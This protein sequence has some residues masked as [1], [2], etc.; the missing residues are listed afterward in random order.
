MAIHL[1]GLPGECPLSRADEQ[2]VSHAWPCSGWGLPSRRGRPR[3]W[4]A[5]TAPFHPYLCGPE[6][7]IGGFLSVALSCGSPRLA[8]SQHPALRSPDLPRHDPVSGPCRGHPAGSPSTPLC[9]GPAAPGRGCSG[10]ARVPQASEGLHGRQRRDGDRQRN[11]C[12]RE[13]HLPVAGIQRHELDQ[14]CRGDQRN[15]HPG[16]GRRRQGTAG[17]GDL[18]RRRGGS[19][20]HD[21]FGWCDSGGRGRRSCGDTRRIDQRKCSPGNRRHRDGGDGQRS[22]CSVGG[23]LFV[24]GVDQRNRLDT[25][26][27]HLQLHA[28]RGRRRQ[29]PAP[30]G[31]LCRR[32][33][34]TGEHDYLR[35]HRA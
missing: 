4:C 10:A 35:R 12:S 28:D 17:G 11:R 9:H 13:R 26:Q 8:V 22:R 25:G 30:G 7:A 20:E 18:C 1:S 15:L 27:Q 2:P 23:C 34:G 14:Y 33:G 5:L 31:D 29:G 16:R 19:R 32:C 21:S 3:R 6:P 24:A